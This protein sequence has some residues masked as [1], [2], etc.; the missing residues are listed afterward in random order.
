M[1][2]LS[3]TAIKAAKPSTTPLRL[4]DE[5]GMYLLLNPDGS[6]WW[7][8]D[9]RIFGKRKTLSLGVYP[10]VSL[11]VARERRETARVDI[12]AGID[13]SAKRQAA[14]Q[15]PANS[16]EAVARVWFDKFKP[17]WVDSHADKIIRRFERDIFPWIGEHAIESIKAPDVLTV[18]RR[19]EARGALETAHR[20]LQNCGQVF[21][22]AV[23]TGRADRDP[24]GDLRGAVPPSKGKNHAAITEPPRIG[25]LLRAIDGYQGTLVTR[26]ALRLSPFVFVRPG[27][28]RRAE[29]VEMN[30]DASEWRIPASRMKMKEPHIVP[31][32]KQAV[33]ILRELQ[34]QTGDGR[35]VF[36]SARSAQRPMS[37][38]AILAALRRMGYG[39]DDMTG[40]G[41]R[42]MARTVL[43]E[44]LG[45]RVDWIEHQLAHAVKD[46]NGR[47]YNRTAHL[48]QRHKM[49]QMWADYLDKLRTGA[50]IL[51]FS[52][53]NVPSR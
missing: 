8:L 38:N 50:T 3:D 24:S 26:A 7:R 41:F 35:Y 11:K 39:N 6:R 10:D 16:F 27:E 5:R 37:E 31:L 47:A 53:S 44:V 49:M 51:P 13:P 20:A 46:A 14:K 48:P 30:L 15:A 1:P 34:P 23:A 18:V 40:H 2:P 4:S 43:D 29:W 32:A 17:Q 42:A 25:E 9:Y 45:Q 52:R 36:P 12:A 19:I 22:Y 28:L 33:A 21:R